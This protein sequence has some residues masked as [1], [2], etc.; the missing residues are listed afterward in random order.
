MEDVNKLKSKIVENGL[1]IE[2]LAKCFIKQFTIK[3]HQ[4]NATNATKGVYR[5][6]SNPKETNQS[7]P[8]A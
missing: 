6:T 7:H 1:T 8:R 4:N 3:T 5:G 2:K